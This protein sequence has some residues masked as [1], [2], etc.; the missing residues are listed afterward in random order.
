MLLALIVKVRLLVREVLLLRPRVD[1][2]FPHDGQLLFDAH[3]LGH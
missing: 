3:C 2:E 1:Q